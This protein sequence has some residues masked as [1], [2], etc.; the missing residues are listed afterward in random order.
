MRDACCVRGREGAGG[1]GRGREGAGG[2]RRGRE[3]ARV[4][5]I[6]QGG[7]GT[8]VGYTAPCSPLVMQ[9]LG[10]GAQGW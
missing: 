4:G 8:W 6:R 7:R 3:G 10:F 5:A 1:G 9:G 2:G